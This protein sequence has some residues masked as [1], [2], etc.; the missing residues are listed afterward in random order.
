MKL[1]I[2]A[3]CVVA[4]V[5]LL[6]ALIIKGYNTCNKKLKQQNKNLQKTADTIACTL[7]KFSCINDQTKA[8]LNDIKNKTGLDKY[9]AI[10]DKLVTSDK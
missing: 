1:K 5:V 9:N 4:F 10:N 3:F 2:I 6:Q 8:Q 7:Q